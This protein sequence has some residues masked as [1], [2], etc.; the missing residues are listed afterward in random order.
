MKPKIFLALA[1]MFVFGAGVAVGK[2]HKTTLKD[3]GFDLTQVEDHIERAQSQIPGGTLVS[4]QL[5][6]AKQSLNTA[7]Q[8]LSDIAQQQNDCSTKPS[9]SLELP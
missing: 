9:S 2:R 4:L 6:M 5:S 7:R 1:V 8:H 3:V